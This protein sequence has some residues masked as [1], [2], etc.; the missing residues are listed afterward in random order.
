[1]GFEANADN[2]GQILYYRP[3]DQRNVGFPQIFMTNAPDDR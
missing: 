1:M 3:F 2:P